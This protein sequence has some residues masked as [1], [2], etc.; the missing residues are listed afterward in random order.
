MGL[1]P[2]VVDM[3]PNMYKIE[4]ESAFSYLALVKKM[5]SQGKRVISFGIGQPDFPTPEHIKDAAKAALD[6]NFTGY[7]ETQGI[8]EL[9]SAVSEYLNSKYG[10]DV[11]SEE[12]VITPGSKTAIFMAAASYIRD[13]DEAIIIEPSYY[14]YA[15]VVKLFNGIPKFVSLDFTPGKGFSLN[16]EKVEKA[17]TKKTRM[18]FIN[19]PHNPTGAV[20]DPKD[21]DYLMEIV[22]KNNIIVVADEIYDNLIYTS[23]FKSL[24]TYPEWR[25]NLIYINGFSKTFSMT[26]WRLAYLVARKE[27]IPRFND[28]AVSLYSCAT[29]FVQKA[30]VIALK[31]DWNPVKNMVKE[32]HERA[33]VLH[34]ILKDAQGFDVYMP[35]GAFYMFP[36]VSGILNKLNISVKGLVDMMLN[37]IGVLV[38]PGDAFPDKAGREFVRFSYATD[39]ESIKEGARKIVEFVNSL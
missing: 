38:L 5:Q 37:K 16:A 25:D 24:I 35:E 15:Q 12:V 13:G 28:L 9:R 39:M 27:L 4:G 29:S 36:R 10:S 3:Q 7:T 30:G 2:P 32:F 21:L 20:F 31:G 1:N 26:G 17:V 34:D 6:D 19:N 18:I 22:K 33:K 23:K 8:E 11:S 14:A